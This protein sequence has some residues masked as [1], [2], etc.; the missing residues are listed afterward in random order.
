MV[1]LEHYDVVFN[2]LSCQ[3]SQEIKMYGVNCYVKR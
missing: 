1:E 3:I 2:Q